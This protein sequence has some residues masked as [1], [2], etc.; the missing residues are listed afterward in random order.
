MVKTN[1]DSNI[2]IIPT[3]MYVCMYVCMYYNY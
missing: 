3:R 1:T 2:N